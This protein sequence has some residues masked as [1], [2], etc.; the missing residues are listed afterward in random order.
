[1]IEIANMYQQNIF[2]INIAVNKIFK[3]TKLIH[4]KK[5]CFCIYV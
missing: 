2:R 1:M 3:K 4:F 5:Y